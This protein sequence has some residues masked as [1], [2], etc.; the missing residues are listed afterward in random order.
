MKKLASQT[1]LIVLKKTVRVAPYLVR[2]LLVNAR[3]EINESL[4]SG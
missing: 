2:H 1:G 3:D 4:G